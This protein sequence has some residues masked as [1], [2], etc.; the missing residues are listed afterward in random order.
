[1]S[2]N[3]EIAHILSQAWNLYNSANFVR[4]LEFTFGKELASPPKFERLY[5]AQASCGDALKG[6]IGGE[7]EHWW[8][9]ENGRLNDY[10]DKEFKYVVKDDFYLEPVIKYYADGGWLA[11]GERLGPSIS[12]RKVGKLEH[13]DG[14]LAITGIRVIWST[15]SR[16][17]NRPL[18]ELKINPGT[19]GAL[20]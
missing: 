2:E 3:Y 14:G 17:I 10:D 5:I 15:N 6:V 18:N 9:M 1:M 8:Y 20:F 11:I 13:K 7:I 4:Y 19:D 12:C 16:I